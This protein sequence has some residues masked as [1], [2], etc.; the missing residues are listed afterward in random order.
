[1]P[2]LTKENIEKIAYH[3]IRAAGAPDGHATTVARHLAEANMVGHDSHGFLRVP[4][5]VKEIGEGRL[6]PTAQP[7]VLSDTVSIARIDGHSTFGQVVATFATELA[8]D[9]ARK[10]GTSLVTMRNLTHT[11]RIGT[12]PEM[13]TRA[14]M[15]AFMFVGIAGGRY[16]GVVPFGG[17]SGRIATNPISIGFPYEPD[18]PILLDMATSMAAEG[19]LRVYRAKGQKLPD[20]WVLNKDGVPSDDPNDYYDGGAILPMGGLHGGHKGFALSFMMIMF[21]QVMAEL[22]SDYRRKDNSQGESSIIVVDVGRMA[23]MESF[24]ER[25]GE[26]VRYVKDTPPMEGASGVLYPGE[27][28]A[29]NR[30]DRLANG[31]SVERST[32]DEVAALIEEYGLQDEL[33]S[34]VADS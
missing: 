5:Y 23:P 20:K 31:V 33:G 19:K 7:E 16:T 8:I 2:T 29:R 15:A 26:F 22:G 18:A 1:M 21:G 32:W 4:Q 12:Y 13:A 10:Y 28:E 14:G 11:G 24:R 6:D 30:R 17:R 34:L 3:V 9:K 27:F 25:V